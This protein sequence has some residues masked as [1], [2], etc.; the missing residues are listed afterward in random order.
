MNS[1]VL[2]SKLADPKGR[3]RQL[4]VSDRS[5]A[6]LVGEVYLLLLNRL[7]SE[8]ERQLAL[9]A[10]AQPGATRQTAVED[11]FWALLNSPEFVL[12]H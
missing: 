11:V 12:N 1:K 2:Q 7:P 10:F 8:S 3:V 4:A 6:E 5:D 9:R